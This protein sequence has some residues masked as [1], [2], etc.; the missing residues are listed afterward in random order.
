MALLLAVTSAKGA[1][2]VTSGVSFDIPSS[3][4]TYTYSVT[5][6]NPDFDIATL[7]IPIGEGV[8]VVNP[9]SPTGF[10]IISDG[11]PVNLVT[12]YEDTDPGT[13]DTFAPGTT[14]GFFSYQS[15]SAPGTVTFSALDANGDTYTGT[16][17]SAVPEPAAPLMVLAAALPLLA[18]RRRNRV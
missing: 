9:T 12:F 14:R 2:V 4:Y 11:D 15:T 10:G 18:S 7:D 3:T 8:T 16:A 1:V 17:L 13:T 5:N 6:A